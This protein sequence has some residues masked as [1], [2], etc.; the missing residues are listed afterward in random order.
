MEGMKRLIGIIIGC[1]AGPIFAAA[2]LPLETSSYGP[3][4]IPLPDHVS[5]A[6]RLP[7]TVTIGQRIPARLVVQNGGLT[8]IKISTGGDYRATGYS[9]RI[10]VRATDSSDRALPMLPTAAYGFGGG[11]F[12]KETVVE[13][14]KNA[15]VEFFLECYVSFPKAGRYSVIAGHDFGWSTND[16][17]L[18]PVGT[19]KINVREPTREQAAAIVDAIYRATAEFDRSGT[20]GSD[21]RERVI[22]ARTSLLRHPRFLEALESRAARGSTAAVLGIGHISTTDATNGLL[23]LLHHRSIPLVGAAARELL[24]RLPSR[25]NPSRSASPDSRISP[26]Q[27]DPLLPTSWDSR[28][29]KPLRAAALQML[30]RPDVEMVEA[31]ALLL[32]S[33]AESEHAPALLAAL[34]R[35][36]DTYCAPRSGAGANALGPPRPQRAILEALDALRQ[37]GWRAMPGST[38]NLVALFR[39]L[40]DETIPKPERGTWEQSMLPW[41]EN[42]PATLRIAALE[43][44]PLPLSPEHERSVTAALGDPDWGV[45]RA[46]CEVAGKS[47]S[48]GFAP[49]LVRIV[50]TMHENFVQDAA[51]RAAL[52]CGTTVALWQAWANVI[53]NKERMFSALHALVDG[54]IALPAQPGGRMGNSNFNPDQRIAIRNAWQHFIHEHESQLAAGTRIR[55]VDVATLAKLTGMDAKP[56]QP[57]YQIDLRD[58]TRWPRR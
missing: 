33:R 31:A 54:T 26:F 45:V 32:Q 11:G 29:E 50:E 10:K 40:A 3:S 36:L 8:P 51:H 47:R 14:G 52:A 44:V 25:E 48:A 58:G 49:P 2:A 1:A 27:I 18:R 46:A 30:L 16:P 9:Q 13:P 39:Q 5:V 15:E 37:R 12:M 43:A 55:D 41:I 17:H 34:Q 20:S 57:A 19:A 4:P 38:A 21:A 56:D 42:G 23:N 35:A 53:P 6:L 7:D 22:E 28:F 24:R